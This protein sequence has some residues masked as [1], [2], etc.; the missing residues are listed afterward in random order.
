MGNILTD[1][2][3]ND[4]SVLKDS[5]ICNICN[6]WKDIYNSVFLYDGGAPPV[7]VV[8]R[9]PYFYLADLGPVPFLLYLRS[10]YQNQVKVLLQLILPD[11]YHQCNY[12][13]NNNHFCVL[14]ILL[15]RNRLAE[16][17]VPVY[18]V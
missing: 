1:I 17:L 9:A 15:Y 8:L 12:I 6:I 10:S 5:D 2:C 18:N 14:D 13:D 3:G 7:V 4:I 16:K 11:M